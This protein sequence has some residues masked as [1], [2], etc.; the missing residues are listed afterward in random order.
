[1]LVSLMDPVISKEGAH[2]LAQ[3][4]RVRRTTRAESCCSLELWCEMLKGQE[5]SELEK[6]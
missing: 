1:M 2:I 3:E 4:V 5:D 6:L